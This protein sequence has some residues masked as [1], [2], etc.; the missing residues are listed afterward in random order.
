MTKT[1]SDTNFKEILTSP[2]VIVSGI[3]VLSLGG[4]AFWYFRKKQKEQVKGEAKVLAQNATYKPTPI[5]KYIPKP[6]PGGMRSKYV[7]PYIKYGSRH[8]DVKVL[9]RFLKFKKADIGKTGRNRDG[10][11]GIFGPK[12]LKASKQYLNKTQFSRMDINGMKAALQK[13]GLA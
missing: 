5:K 12:T 9:Q 11:D 8:S 7:L 4:V 1:I 10:V 3:S 13:T 2:W 6:R